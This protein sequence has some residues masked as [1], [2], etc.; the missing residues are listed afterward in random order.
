MA[1]PQILVLFV[2]SILGGILNA[3][4]GGGS[5]FTFP[6]LIVT[7][8]SA[9]Q[10]N[11]TST[12]ALWPGT[13]ASVGAYRRELKKQKRGLLL[14]LVGISLI[15]GV[16]GAILLL[17][18][19][20][21]VFVLLIPYLLLLATLLFAFSGPVTA[22]LRTRSINKTR[23]SWRSFIGLAVAQFIISIYGGYFGGGIG[24]LMLAT[25]AMMGLD[26]IHE[27]NALKTLL[28]SCINGIAVV[29][30]IIAGAVVWF[31]AILMIFGA[32]LGGYGG[33]YYARK[34]DPR[35]VRLFVIVV[36][37]VL[38]IYFFLRR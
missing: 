9:I 2:A 27:M 16:L 38:T 6:S 13:I 17:R 4:A 30:F 31:Q 24:I 29:T 19:S 12:V 14:L 23:L 20:Q 22:R 32:I 15:G 1:L 11:A 18:T 21:A 37:I 36:G 33:A 25:L 5:F 28:A 10:A 3:V 8:V 26:N 7:G 35:W 34:I